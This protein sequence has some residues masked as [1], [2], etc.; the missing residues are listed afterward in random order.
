MEYRLLVDL[1]VIEV[2]DRMPKAQRQRFLALFD[3][4]RAFP[5]NYSDYYEADAVGR[6]VE[7][8]IL[9]HWAIHYWI[10]GADRHVKILAIRSADV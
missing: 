6:R 2:M 3:K 4:L 1:E 7:V 9:S 10:D 8:C 5:S